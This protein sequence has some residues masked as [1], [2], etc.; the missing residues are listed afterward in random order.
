MM[1][2]KIFYFLLVGFMSFSASSMADDQS[3]SVRLPSAQVQT[4]NSSEVK[5]VDSTSGEVARFCQNIASQ[6]QDARFE[7]QLRQLDVMRNQIEMRINLLEKKR[8]EYD[9]WLARRNAFLTKTQ[10]SF[11]GIIS[12]MRPDAA[13]AQLS[14]LDEVAAASIILKLEPRISS[15]IMNELQ[16]EKSANLM[17]VLVSVQKVPLEK[18]SKSTPTVKTSM[19]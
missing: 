15:A 3:T 14:L 7:L 17:R 9:D 19:P 18:V 1:K 5:A 16:A 6:A 8:K 2:K 11:V 13:A 10:D 4:E 12:R